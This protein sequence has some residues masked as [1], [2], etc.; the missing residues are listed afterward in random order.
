M[1]S[2]ILEFFKFTIL[3][4]IHSDKGLCI[5]SLPMNQVSNTI[6]VIFLTKEF[7]VIKISNQFYNM[8]IKFIL[9]LFLS[10]WVSKYH[11]HGEEYLYEI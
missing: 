2:M 9:K 3:H 4:I 11:M 8:V 6:M 10:K 7:I 1:F 5:Q